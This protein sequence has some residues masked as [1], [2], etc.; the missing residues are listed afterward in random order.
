MPASLKRGDQIMLAAPARFVQPEDVILAKETIEKA[1][2]KAVIPSDLEARDGQFGGADSHRSG[3]INQPTNPL[4]S[5]FFD[6]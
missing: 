2:F 1:G 6:C 4:D 3:I 5:D